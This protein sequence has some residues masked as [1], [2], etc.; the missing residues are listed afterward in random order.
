M[1]KL[2]ARAALAAALTAA[3]ATAHSA[4]IFS[5]DFN[6]AGFAAGNTFTHF[7]DRFGP[8]LYQSIANFNGWTFTGQDFW[9]TKVGTT[10]SAVLMNEGPLGGM[11]HALTGLV[12]GQT[13]T[14]DFLLSGDNIPGAAYGLQTY[15]GNNLLLTSYGVDANSGGTTGSQKTVSFVAQSTST[16]L[17]FQAVYQNNVYTGA[18]PIVDNVVVSTADVP[19]PASLALV[20]VALLG[21]SAA[22]RRQ[23]G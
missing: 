1:K 17:R 18:S 3:A 6:N 4:V 15:E 11:S 10:D 19:E 21:L 5:E 9:A 16:T 20:G 7:S 14:V 23:R 12:V 2:F 8:T 13:Y 22:R